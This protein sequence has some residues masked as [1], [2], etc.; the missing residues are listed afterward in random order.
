MQLVHDS[1]L[2]AITPAAL[3][4]PFERKAAGALTAP[5][6]FAAERP[7]LSEVALI[8]APG[9]VGQSSPPLASFPSQ[10]RTSFASLASWSALWLLSIATR[11][12]TSDYEL[13]SRY[14]CLS[15]L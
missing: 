5:H 10:N 3:A 8:P 14:A 9:R 2:M 13:W 4:R 11:A 1:L 6:R 7:A 15:M 12:L